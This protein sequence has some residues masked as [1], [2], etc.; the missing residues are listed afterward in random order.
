MGHPQEPRLNFGVNYWSGII[1]TEA[2]S[3]VETTDAL[4][5]RVRH[6]PSSA[7]N[8]VLAKNCK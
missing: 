4:Q 8:N 7:F 2:P 1:L 6:P 5:R 3:I